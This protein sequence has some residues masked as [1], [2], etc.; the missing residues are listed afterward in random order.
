MSGLCNQNITA[1]VQFSLISGINVCG[2]VNGGCR[3]DVYEYKKVLCKHKLKM[4]WIP[5]NFVK[6]GGI[7]YNAKSSIIKKIYMFSLL[8][9]QS[10]YKVIANML[11]KNQL[12]EKHL[13]KW[14]EKKKYIFT[15]LNRFNCKYI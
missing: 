15:N 4:E 8:V 1:Q 7:E 12:K 13:L 6:E 14:V 10:C 5:F 2:L 11:S 9:K 3:N